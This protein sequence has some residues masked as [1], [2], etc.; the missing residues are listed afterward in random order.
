MQ[1]AALAAAA[2]AAGLLAAWATASSH[3]TQASTAFGNGFVTFRYPA[4]WSATVWKEHVLHFDPMVYLSTERSQ[5]DP[6][7]SDGA[8]TVCG[9]PVTRLDRNGLIVK[10][11]NR[12]F[13]GTNV[14]TFPGKTT[15]IGG[16]PAR[17]SISRPG[18]CRDVG[19][20]ETISVAI[21]RPLQSNW[22]QVDAC[23]RGPDISTLEQQVHELLG[24]ARFSAPENGGRA[25]APNGRS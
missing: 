12:G 24:S 5:H 19:A 20:D 3:T 9:W 10:W 16:R 23:L 6:C 22:T 7:R 18:T 2:V 4:S 11:E 8:N 14:G 13:P 15:L 25:A 21:A 1:M 17:V